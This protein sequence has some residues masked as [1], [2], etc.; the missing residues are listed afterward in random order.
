M[1]I[2]IL[3]TAML[4]G[5]ADAPLR[6][7]SAKLV[8]PGLRGGASI[9]VKIQDVRAGVKVT[10]PVKMEKAGGASAIRS[11]RPLAIA[12]PPEAKKEANRLQQ[13]VNEDE[14]KEQQADDQLKLSRDHKQ[15]I[16]DAIKKALDLKAEGNKAVQ[17]FGR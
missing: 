2:A 5:C 12:S 13:K 6:A 9:G 8:N 1:R 14:K 11:A 17:D 15:A 3:A 7:E 10:A 16:K 4:L